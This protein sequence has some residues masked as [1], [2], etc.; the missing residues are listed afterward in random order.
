MRIAIEQKEL[1][2]ATSM[3]L[4]LKQYGLHRDQRPC[5]RRQ[6]TTKGRGDNCLR[7]RSVGGGGC[8]WSV[9]CQRGTCWHRLRTSSFWTGLRLKPRTYARNP[10]VGLG[11]INQ[12]ENAK[13]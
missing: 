2:S 9:A 1:T 12:W 13:G 6:F 5:L 8:R 3:R 4:S 11:A 7:D 10:G